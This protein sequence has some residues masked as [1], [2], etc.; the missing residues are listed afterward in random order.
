[1]GSLFALNSTNAEPKIT[2]LPVVLLS[3]LATPPAVSTLEPECSAP[4]SEQLLLGLS[5]HASSPEGPPIPDNSL[6]VGFLPSPPPT[7]L[8]TPPSSFKALIFRKYLVY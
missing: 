3:V 5:T 4:R 2:S 1:M 7:V 8:T 6:Q